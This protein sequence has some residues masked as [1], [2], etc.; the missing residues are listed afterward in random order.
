MESI[1]LKENIN[2]KKLEIVGQELEKGKIAIFPTE[3]VYG[4][5]TNGLN[6]EAV[7]K[8]FKVKK[9]DLNKP[10]SLLVSNIEM[11]ENI[12]KDISELEYKLMKTFFP[13]P[14]TLILKKKENIPDILTA[15]KDTVGVRIPDCEI[16]KKLIEFGGCPI[17]APSANISGELP[18]TN[19]NSIFETFKDKV[20]YIID[21]GDSRIGLSSTI[22][23]VID[24]VPKILREGTITRKQIENCLEDLH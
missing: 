15:N 12:A 14:F 18:A 24:G 1:N 3:T 2:Y 7:G 19:I 16:T 4:I 20:D 6:T 23:Q 8:L 21:G 17:A 22:V 13:G 10:I 9:R 5:G 11:V